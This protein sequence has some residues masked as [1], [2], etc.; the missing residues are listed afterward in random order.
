VKV[1]VTG[2]AG[3]LGT[4][5]LR[6][7]IADAAVEQ[8]TSIDVRPP[9]VSDAKLRH[10]VRDIRDPGLAEL[11]AGCDRVVHLA[12]VVTGH[13]PRHVFDD[14]NVRGSQNLFR[15]AAA[16]GVA[17]VVYTSS[18]AAYGVVP[19]HPEPIVENTPRVHQ[20]QFAYAS[21]KYE[22]EQFLDQFEAK[23][24]IKIVRLRP[25][26]LLG[27]GMT[28]PLQRLL[29]HRL[30]VDTDDRPLPIVSDED[31]VAAIAL[32]LSREAQGAYILAADEP[33]SGAALARACGLGLIRVPQPVAV[34]AGQLLPLLAKT[35][36]FESID[37]AWT[38]VGDVRM[39]FDSSK[40]R[41]ELGWQPHTATEVI[42]QVV[43]GVRADPRHEMI[44]SA[45]RFVG[46]VG[47]G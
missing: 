42:Q 10:F 11:L 16:A 19:G 14:I 30:M 5:L 37:P 3:Q 25:A 38:R 23:N 6:R 20:R 32:A 36:L 22:V 47:A 9:R 17:Q 13:P 4:T 43:E 45:L 18:I 46:L 1:A 24:P 40:A 27:A 39:V 12:F 35:G 29:R 15:A 21:A 31:V 44:L 28:H 34:G 8:L 41:R 26:I 33:Q 7:L 2:G